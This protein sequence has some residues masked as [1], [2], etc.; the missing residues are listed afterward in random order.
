MVK[1]KKFDPTRFRKLATK[2]DPKKQAEG[3][4]KRLKA[5]GVEEEDLDS[6]NILEKALNLTPD[7]NALFDLFEIINRPQ[8]ALFGGINAEQKGKSFAEG[9]KQGISRKGDFGEVYFKDIL[10][11]EGVSDSGEKV[12]FDDVLGFAGEIFLDPIDI[13]LIPITKGAK[14]FKLATKRVGDAAEVLEKT[15][16]NYN[17]AKDAA[18]G[19]KKGQDGYETFRKATLAAK[20]EKKAA[21]QTFNL[22]KDALSKMKTPKKEMYS[23]LR[24]GMLGAKES[25]KSTFNLAD[26]GISKGLAKLDKVDK[27]KFIDAGVEE[28]YNHITRSSKYTE[29]KRRITGIFDA[30]KTFPKDIWEKATKNIG[31]EH[32]TRANLGIKSKQLTERVNEYA[33]LHNLDAQKLN[34]DLMFYIEGRMYKPKGSIYKDVIKDHNQFIDQKFLNFLKPAADLVDVKL[35]DIYELRKTKDGVT[36]FV[37]D[38]KELRNF[39]KKLE[40]KLQLDGKSQPFS[41]SLSLEEQLLAEIELPRFYSKKDLK[42]MKQLDL[43]KDF[44][45]LVDE[46]YTTYRDLLKTVD[47]AFNDLL[48]FRKLPEGYLRHATTEDFGFIKKHQQDLFN[49]LTEGEFETT[50]KGTTRTFSGRKYKMSA[51]E[52]NNILNAQIQNAIENKD[53]SEAVRNFWANKENFKLFDDAI[54]ASVADFVGEAPKFAKD[55]SQLYDVLVVGSLQDQNIIK[56]ITSGRA[57]KTPSGFQEISRDELIARLKTVKKFVEPEAGK[58]IDKAIRGLPAYERIALDNNVFMLTGRLVN[59]KETSDLVRLLDSINLIFKKNKL[60][61][62]GFQMRNFVGNSTN[63]YLAGMSP[64][65]IAKN[66]K[67][68]DK[69]IK[70]GDALLDKSVRGVALS[71][72]EK[73]DLALYEEFLQNGFHNVAQELWDIPESIINKKSKDQRNIFRKKLGQVQEFNNDLNMAADKRFRL[74]MLMWAKENPEKWAGS[75]AKTPVEMVRRVLFDPNDLSFAERNYIKKTIPFYTFAKKNL[76]YQMKNIFDNPTRYKNLEKTVNNLWR[77]QGISEKDI[78]VY[79]REN[80]WIPVPNLTKDGKYVAL[81]VNLPVGDLAEFVDDP[82]RRI[83]SS[84]SPA[85]RSPFEI[86]ANKQMYSN[87]PIEEFKGQK[88]FMIPELDRRSEYLL[89]QTGL[90]V[91]IAGLADVG[92]TVSKVA[93]GEMDISSP[94]DAIDQTVGRSLFSTGSLEKAERTRAFQEIDELTDLMKLYQQKG[95][96]I[97]KLSEISNNKNT[98]LQ[99]V[100]ARLKALNS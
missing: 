69:I 82:M 38:E 1:L 73:A 80:F 78:E 23:P 9:A 90:D 53:V 46:A 88:G 36:Y 64:N 71:A 58:S 54:N 29:F 37:A 7:Q 17:L 68:A 21:E 43:D 50:L 97:P 65:E 27:Q 19:I 95:I 94:F 85:I 60:L 32:L 15:V 10:H 100:N 79:K 89:G 48:E 91:P 14:A 83:I 11:E 70:K 16:K 18:R 98:Y 5:A 40:D 57:G 30:A 49:K 52:T 51:H 4:K 2:Y 96:N 33:K 56:P 22:A 99:R 63:L 61:S 45:G 87:M 44:L 55:I 24:A 28:S 86:V 31:T 76:A 84:M 42:R 8:R 3:L 39:V 62:P 13:P 74:S 34:E 26:K 20:K 77:S 12:G 25:I 93:K 35:D 6:R 41:T 66:F 67:R 72:A 81:K 59:Q 47:S 75:D 92:R